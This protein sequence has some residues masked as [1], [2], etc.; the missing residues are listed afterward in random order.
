VTRATGRL[1]MRQRI[2]DSISHRGGAL[3]IIADHPFARNAF[4]TPIHRRIVCRA[5]R[6]K[7]AVFGIGTKFALILLSSSTDLTHLWEGD[8]K[9]D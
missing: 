8:L 4:A 1:V 6:A 3:P 7:R 9:W 2:D 5:R